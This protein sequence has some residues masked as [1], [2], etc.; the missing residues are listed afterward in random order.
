MKPTDRYFET[1]NFY[2]AAVLFA[3][4]F[5]LVNIR[6]GGSRRSTFVFVLSPEIEQLAN[7][8]FYAKENS[9]EMMIDARM[10]VTAIRNLKDKLYQH[11][12]L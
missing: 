5:E 10:I 2:L 6:D 9:S 3:K 7:N 12:D 8:F 4:N 1:T 11:K